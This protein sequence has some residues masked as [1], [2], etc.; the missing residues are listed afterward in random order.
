MGA[1]VSLFNFAI[2]F[3]VLVVVFLLVLFLVVLKDGNSDV[4]PTAT[5]VP[6]VDIGVFF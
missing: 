3:A 1:I 5:E 2:G 6:I 4:S